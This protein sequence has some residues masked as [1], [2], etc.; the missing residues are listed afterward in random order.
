MPRR[1]PLTSTSV[2][3]GPRP[4]R[5]T[6]A[7][8][9]GVLN[10]EEV[11]LKEVNAFCRFCG[12]W[13]SRSTMSVLPPCRIS[14]EVTTC[15]GLVLWEFGVRM[16][17][18]VI[19]TSSSDSDAAGAASAAAA[20]PAGANAAMR[21]TVHAAA[22]SVVQR[23][24]LKARRGNM[25]MKFPR[26]SCLSGNL[27]GNRSGGNFVLAT[28]QA[29]AEHGAAQAAQPAR[30]RLTHR[31][32]RY[33]CYGFAPLREAAFGRGRCAEPC[34]SYG[35]GSDRS[36]CETGG[37]SPAACRASTPARNHHGTTGASRRSV[38]R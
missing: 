35:R 8:P 27:G 2:R 32:C 22:T 28:Q 4:R 37:S 7:I 11:L 20:R 12:S 33:C 26:K 24:G 29:P 1:R 17:E 36:D 25:L 3:C 21:P 14:L 13:L 5:S 15:I 23:G 30:E 38:R 18:P 9:P 6:V 34:L 10:P 19:T 16:R 31:C